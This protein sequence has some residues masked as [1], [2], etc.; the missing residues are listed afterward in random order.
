MQ[1]CQLQ[2][3]SCSPPLQGVPVKGGGTNVVGLARMVE[4]IAERVERVCERWF[5][6]NRGA[7]PGFCTRKVFPLSK[8]HSQAEQ[9]VSA[10]GKKKKKK[11]KKAPHRRENRNES[12]N[13]SEEAVTHPNATLSGA[14]WIGRAAVLVRLPGY[15]T[16]SWGRR[17]GGGRRWPRPHPIGRHRAAHRLASRRRHPRKSHTRPRRQKA[18]H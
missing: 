11:R 7:V 14:G 1:W 5:D 9:P 6:L 17:L 4:Q 15:L 18:D 2:R 3:H 13:P 12:N 10:A 8:D 16:R